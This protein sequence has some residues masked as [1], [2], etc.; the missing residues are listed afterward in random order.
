MTPIVPL[1]F[2]DLPLALGLIAI[3]LVLS[4]WHRLGLEGALAIA[5]GRALLQL[6]V[7]GYLL[8]LLF[9]VS[10]PWLVIL[11]ILV[12]VLLAAITVRNQISRK[13]PHLLFLSGGSMLV[14]LLCSLSYTIL[15]IIQPEEWY[16]P[17]YWLS[18]T[19]IGV[20]A[21]MNGGAIAGER[22]VSTLRTSRLEIETR[23]SLGAN[24]PQAIEPYRRD[25]I[26]AGML[27]T[28]NSMAIAGMVT[29][30]SV[31]SGQLLSGVDPL[32]AVAY[33]VLILF[34]LILITLSTTL[35]MTQGLC[36]QFFN[37]AEQLVLP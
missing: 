21:A 18:L 23:L 14:S 22:L 19:A 12:L 33:Q 29:L 10:N 25:A 7:A 27:P 2:L 6:T 26:R 28:I 31:F 15:L 11:G 3:A 37:A 32:E 24:P 36:R 16:A 30:P 1:D 20:A 5:A 4:I 34:M 9:G 13:V 8:T 17:Q 35:L